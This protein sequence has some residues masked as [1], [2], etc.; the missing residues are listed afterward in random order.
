MNKPFRFLV[1]LAL[2]GLAAACGEP[3]PPPATPE[4][5]D[6]FVARVNDDLRQMLP[7]ISKANWVSVTYITEDTQLLAAK[8]NEEYLAYLGK[9]IEESKRFDGLP[10]KPET[11]RA[12]KLLRLGTANPA[13]KDPAKLAELTQIITR[14]EGTYGAGKYCPGGEE[15][16]R[17]LDELSRVLADPGKHSYEELTEAWSGWHTISRPIKA[18]YVRFVELTNEGAR[19]L[20]YENLGVMWRSAYDMDP[21]AFQQET[22]RLWQQVKP[23]YDQ[24]H[25]YVRHELHRRYGDKVPAT[26]PIPAQLLGNMWAQEWGNIYPLVEPYKAGT[27][28][29]V[30]GTLKARRDAEEKRL[31]AALKERT[32]EALIETARRADDWIAREMVRSAE[33][34]YTSLGLRELPDSFWDK[35]MFLRPRDRDVVC[36]ASAWDMDLQGDVRIKM[37]ITPTEEDLATI[38]HELGHLYYDLAYN[39]LPPI[40][41]AGAHD[42]FHEAIGDTIVLAMTPAYLH[43]VGL[44]KAAGQKSREALINEQLKSALDKIAFLPF[45]LLIDRWRWDVFAGKVKPE[46]YNAAWWELRQKYQGV[47]APVA[48]TEEDF[49]PGAKYHVPANTPYTRYFLARILQFQFYRALCETAGHEGP[50]HTCSFFGSR[51]AGE[52]FWAMLAM[53]ASQPWPQTLEKLTGKPE[54]DASAIV[55]YYQPLM[56]WLEEQNKGRQCGW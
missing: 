7:R 5:A 13:P 43:S 15:T 48:R 40:F 36:H 12:I 23:L 55:E 39:P 26:G 52:K 49:D 16:C 34:F 31:L 17:N 47:A 18:D 19:E 53:G 35:S 11:A 42:G 33:S 27:D 21:D 24:L 50:L 46:N 14:M 6:A 29:D 32:P 10:L 28:L 30:T 22:D 45:G 9:A 54:M 25:C 51:E 44:V 4:E 56:Q 20:G 37:C 41:Q 2:G 38:Y 8:A 1:A 3:T